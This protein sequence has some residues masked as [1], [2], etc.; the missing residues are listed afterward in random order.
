MLGP[1]LIAAQ[2]LQLVQSSSIAIDAPEDYRAYYAKLEGEAHVYTINAD[3]PFRLSAA[4]LVPY[5]E[6]AKTDISAAI[7]DPSKPD[8]PIALLDGTGQE[9]IPFVDTAGRDDYLAG[10]LFKAGVDRGTYEIRVWSSN[11]DSAYVLVIGEEGSFS[12][13][14]IIKR[15]TTLPAIKSEFFGKSPSSAFLTPLLLWPILGLVTALLVVGIVTGI[16]LR[17]RTHTIS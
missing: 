12:I 16:L 14:E 17:R 15:Y 1:L 9:W 11:N 7:V 2:E 13:G 3:D 8:V 6:G 4:L 10:P 5:V